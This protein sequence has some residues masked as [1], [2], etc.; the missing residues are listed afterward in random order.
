M[1]AAERIVPGPELTA[2]LEAE[3]AALQAKHPA[4]FLLRLHVLGDFYS[5]EYVEFWQRM[6]QALPALHVFGFT[7]HA[8]ASELGRAIARLSLEQGWNRWAI[9]FSGAPH[10]LRASRVLGPGES[11]HAAI[12]CPAQTGATDC[13]ATCALC[14]QSERAIAF[15]RH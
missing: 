2:A 7:A 13:C 9:R 12:L 5:G 1:Q 6:L 14:W 10:E 4:G 8:P 15:R 11:D 3:L